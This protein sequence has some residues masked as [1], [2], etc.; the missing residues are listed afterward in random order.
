MRTTD[1]RIWAIR[2]KKGRKTPTWEFRWKTGDQS[3]S[4][5]RQTKG[6]AESF[7]SDLRQATKRGE[8]FDV[9][10]GLPVS[11]L[12]AQQEQAV[13]PEKPVTFLTFAQEYVTRLWPRDAPKTR[14]S[15]SDALATVVPALT[16]DAPGRP[17]S[18]DLRTVLRKYLLLPEDKRPEPPADMS[19]TISWLESASLPLTAVGEARHAR[20]ALDALTVNLDGTKS[21][22]TTI[23]RK[24]GVFFNI[25]EYAVELEILPANPIP[26]LKWKPPK[27]SQTVDP[28]VVVN[29]DQAHALLE[30]VKSVGD[31]K[32]GRGQRLS[33]MFA[34]MYYAAMRP[35]EAIGLR[36][37]DCKLPTKGWGTVTLARSRPEA[38]L[39]WTDTGDAHEERGLKHRAE[40]D[41]RPVPIPPVLVRILREHI[42][43]FGTTADGRLF[44]SERDKPVASTS[45]TEVWKEARLL[46][47]TPEQV[48]SPMAGRPYDLRHAAVSL[49]LNGGVAPTEIAQRAGHSVEVLLRVYAKCVSGQEEIANR[50]I[51]EILGEGETTLTSNASADTREASHRG[52]IESPS[53]GR[54][55]AAKRIKTSRMGRDR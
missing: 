22:A 20:A 53:A 23:A 29:Q 54:Q 5:S 8:E 35:S 43:A 15:R 51:E 55:F 32:R 9:E 48:A 40:D 30:A 37:S 17:S 34:C 3:H 21:G 42:Q 2:Q 41:V 39:R 12:E 45:Y 16:S 11:M 18:K 1:V 14:D 36:A 52:T 47:L 44:R 50:R 38:N 46:A 26:K 31:L 10:S 13:E 4:A 25:L 49:W 19:A 33:A 7:Q 6:L 27:T 24:R 28:R